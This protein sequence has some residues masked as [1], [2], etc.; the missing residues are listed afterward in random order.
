M[1][2]DLSQLRDIHL[3]AAVPWWPPA[4]GW[5]ALVALL[6]IAA[7]LVYVIYA[8]RRRNRWRGSALTELAR[9]RDA[10]P[11]RLL[12]EVSVLLRRVAISR[13]PRH[14]VAALTGEAWLAFL[15]RSLGD[16]AAF[17]SGVGRVLLSG[18]YATSHVEVDVVSLLALC[19]RW[20]KRL[21]SKGAV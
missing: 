20:I 15:D 14:D 11:Q 9:L 18:P 3:P 13:F 7:G 5:W 2:P 17:Q 21:P 8:R 4:P 1:K 19:E 12:R 10:S 6:L 16:G